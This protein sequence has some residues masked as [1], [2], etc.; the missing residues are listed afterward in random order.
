MFTS[1]AAARFLRYVTFDT[2]SDES[3]T[4]YPSTEKQLVLL[5]Q[6]VKE[7]QEMGVA[8]AAIDKYGY[9]MA[10]IPASPGKAEAPVVGFI[11]H[12]DT[13]PE[14]SGAGVRPIV[15]QHYDGR[16]LVLPDDPAY[17]LREA[18]NPEL[19]APAWPRHHHGVRPHA[20]GRRRQGRRRRN[21]GR[22]RAPDVASG[23]RRTAR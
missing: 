2:Q 9:V 11:A 16:D 21:H 1:S 22:R 10:T 5:N 20:A 18:D 8:D 3:S 17:V 13:S 4:T 19:A 15:H 7:L 12:V 14:V 23:D 6:L